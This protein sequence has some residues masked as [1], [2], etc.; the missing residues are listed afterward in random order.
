M[1]AGSV[2]VGGVLTY[3]LCR[4]REAKSIPMLEEWWGAG[5]RPEV[6]DDNIYPFTVQTSEEEIQVINEASLPH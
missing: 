2:A 5:V 6:E 1:A 4:K 3:L